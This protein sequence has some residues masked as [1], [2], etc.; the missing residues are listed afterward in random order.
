[1]RIWAAR[2]AALGMKIHDR[3]V[4]ITGEPIAQGMSREIYACPDA[5]D[6]LLK[7]AKPMPPPRRF[8]QRFRL[9]A[10]LRR[11]YKQVVPFVRECREYKRALGEGARARRHLQQLKAVVRTD[12][13][14][15][16]IVHA[17]K[18]KGDQLGM[19]VSDLI[20]NG[21]YDQRSQMQMQEFL[22]W[23][24]SSSVVAADVHLNNIV[25]DEKT[26]A[27]VL[28]D[29]IGDKT[30]F[31]VRAWIPLL[32]RR[33]KERLAREITFG[34]AQSFMDRLLK[35]EVMTSLMLVAGVAIGFDLWDGQLFD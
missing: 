11:H 10:A 25:Y 17:V 35:K 2:M 14:S 34:I 27:M 13:G 21:H 16:M 6:V 33:Y 28:I 15:A 23:F 8:F 22:N 12:R 5:P 31:P 32:N 24:V 20:E 4:E 19:T 26:K 1:M 30:F 3:M 18:G 7:V 9:L 29:G